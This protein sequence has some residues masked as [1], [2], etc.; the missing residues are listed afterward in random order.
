M[1]IEDT[2]RP[3]ETSI[4]TKTLQ[5]LPEELIIYIFSFLS[6]ET[7]TNQTSL[8]CKQFARLSHDN[9]LIKSIILR[10]WPYLSKKRKIDLNFLKIMYTPRV[11]IR[12]LMYKSVCSFQIVVKNQEIFYLGIPPE[13]KIYLRRFRKIPRIKL[14]EKNKKPLFKSPLHPRLRRINE[15]TKDR[16]ATV[17]NTDIRCFCVSGDRFYYTAL[18]Y[19]HSNPKSFINAG[20]WE[21]GLYACSLKKATE[22]SVLQEELLLRNPPLLSNVTKMHVSGDQIFLL[23]REDDETNLYTFSLKMRS[24]IQSYYFKG[25][26]NYVDFSGDLMAYS[27]QNGYFECLDLKTFNII[28]KNRMTSLIKKIKIFHNRL[29]ITTRFEIARFHISGKYAGSL[30]VPACIRTST[31]SYPFLLVLTKK[32]D[33]EVYDIEKWKKINTFKAPASWT[34]IK[35]KDGILFGFGK[36]KYKTKFRVPQIPLTIAK[37]AVS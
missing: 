4:H 13:I 6:F 12:P 34:S 33:I 9:I 15:D 11:C 1:I 5:D 37:I 32:N 28:T 20:W 10:E 24:V 26:I 7:I 29:F 21:R 35:L 25:N 14:E 18:E 8:I 27:V 23:Q 16:S 36:R 19:Y 17:K 2:A 3:P 22:V 30:S 31:I